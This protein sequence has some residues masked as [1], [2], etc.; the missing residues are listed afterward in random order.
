[1]TNFESK[2]IIN[3]MLGFF[4]L[5]LCKVISSGRLETNTIWKF[6]LLKVLF[7]EVLKL[8]NILMYV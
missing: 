7:K 4:L 8:A 1:M 2:V 3:L 5:F 6:M